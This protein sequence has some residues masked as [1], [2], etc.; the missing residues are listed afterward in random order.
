MEA[1][2]QLAYWVLPLEARLSSASLSILRVLLTPEPDKPT[3]PPPTPL[4]IGGVRLIVDESIPPRRI[5]FWDSDGK[6]VRSFK[7]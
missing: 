1:A 3:A 6:I 2:D 5:E 7:I 4:Q